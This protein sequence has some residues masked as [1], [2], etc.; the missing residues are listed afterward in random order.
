MMD[1]LIECVPN[2]SEGRDRGVIDAITAAMTSAGATLLDVDMGAAANRTVVTIAGSPEAVEEAA[3]QGIRQAAERID[4]TRHKGEH[5]RLG[6][7]D[8]CPFVP[9]SGVTMEDCAAVAARVG[10]RVGRELGIPVYLYGRA[11]RCPARASLAD[12]R[13]G[14]YEG[15]AAKLADPG[16]AP[17]FGP[18]AFRP[19]SGATVIGAREFLIAYNVNLNTRDKM[20]ANRIASRIREKG[21]PGR[22]PDGEKLVD[23]TGAAITLPGVLREVR[24]VGWVI[25]EYGIAQVSINLLDYRVTPLHR[26]FEEV[27]ALADEIGIHATGSE[28]VG[29]VPKDA[30]L[31][32]GQWYLDRQGRSPGA[33]E[34]EVIH[35]AVRSLGLSDAKPFVPAEKV[36][37]YRLQQGRTTLTDLTA[38]D[39]ADRVSSDSPAPG[40][41]SVAALCGAL[42]ASLAAMVANLTVRQAKLAPV[43]AD[44]KRLSLEAQALK[45]RLLALVSEDTEAFDAVMAAM[46]LPQGTPEERASRAAAVEAANARAAEVPF[47][48]LRSCRKAASLA[49]EAGKKGFSSCL[50]DAG[51]AAAAALAGAE[52]AY[53]NVAINAKS[54]GDTAQARQLR[55]TAQAVLSETRESCRAAISAI[56]G[57]LGG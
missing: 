52:G 30:L 38:R 13:K 28:I 16:W 20:L 35:I 46:R 25:E 37:E 57:R 8:V 43:H 31:A 21:G 22:A 29:L 26:V 2:F 19:R 45:G 27:R 47:E 15:L 44:M 1:R 5:P 11:A 39:F 9:L 53:L 10:E 51:A 32:A 36:I 24:A 33:P 3:F 14:E 55:E 48:T 7:T 54:M 18:A 12:I 50:S 34:P 17:D 56:T 4:M 40:G 23:P 6:A 49:A 42:G 41:G